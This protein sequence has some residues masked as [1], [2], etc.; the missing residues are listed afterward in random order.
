MEACWA[1]GQLRALKIYH[2]TIRF[3]TIIA[4]LQRNITSRRIQI[5]F[6]IHLA[7]AGMK[8]SH[9]GVSI[10]KRICHAFLP[11]IANAFV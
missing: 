10:T 6:G 8:R 7:I 2:N 5:A 4:D 9:V 11:P 1:Q 3:G